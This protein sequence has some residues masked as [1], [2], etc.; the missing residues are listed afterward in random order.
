MTIHIKYLLCA[1][2]CN[3]LGI[4]GD[5]EKNLHPDAMTSFCSE[6]EAIRQTG[7]QAE[8]DTETESQGE[9]QRQG[10]EGTSDHRTACVAKKKNKAGC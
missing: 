9:R 5:Q 2:H 10:D 8:I 6:Q 3:E 7:R 4:Q 1:K